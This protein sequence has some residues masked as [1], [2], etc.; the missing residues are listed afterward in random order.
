[1]IVHN[2]IYQFNIGNG[3]GKVSQ[4]N[5]MGRYTL[6]IGN[7][8]SDFLK[9]CLEPIG[10]KFLIKWYK[11][12]HKIL[13]YTEFIGDIGWIY[14]VKKSSMSSITQ[15]YKIWWHLRSNIVEMRLLYFSITAL[16]WIF[17]DIKDVIALT[18]C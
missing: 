11:Q 17:N 14:N 8:N 2:I 7:P 9:V 1:M 6:T 12:S 18:L 13:F 10:N 4:Q 5:T 3:S 15:N 16:E